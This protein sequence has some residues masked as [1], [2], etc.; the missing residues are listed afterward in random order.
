MLDL[1]RCASPPYLLPGVLDG[2]ILRHSD[3]SLEDK[4]CTMDRLCT[5]N[6]KEVQELVGNGIQRETFWQSDSR[7][8]GGKS[9]RHI[10]IL[11]QQRIAAVFVGEEN[12]NHNGEKNPWLLDC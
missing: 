2:T 6:A 9:E 5:A 1:I 11:R 10:Q 12:G 8:D 4:H 3:S 7:E